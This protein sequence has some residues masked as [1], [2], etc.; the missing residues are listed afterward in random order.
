MSSIQINLS[1]FSGKIKSKQQ[2]IEFA[3]FM[4]K[5]FF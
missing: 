5:R 1:E 3:Q 4:G 2:A